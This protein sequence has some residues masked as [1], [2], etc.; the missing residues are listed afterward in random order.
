MRV[1]IAST[2]AQS[3]Q[4]RQRL[5]N[6]EETLSYELG[7]AV[8][9]LPPLYT[10]LLAGGISVLV[11]GTLTWAHFSKVDEVAVTQGELIPSVEVRP[12]RALSVGSIQ[13]IQ[14]KE[15]D[16]VKKDQVLV[17]MDSSLPQTDVNRLEKSARLIREDI[18]RLE[19]ERTGGK[20]AGTDLQDQLLTARLRE[21]DTK[22]AAAISES[23][24]QRA[25]REEAKARMSRLQENLINARDN[26]KNAR[27]REQALSSLKGT[28]AVPQL[29]YI[30]AQDELTDAKDKVVSLEKEIDA[31]LER[32]RQAD[33]AYQGA[34]S[35]A[36]GLDSQRRSE[37]LSQLN[38]RYEEQAS[39]V[40]QLEQAKKQRSRETIKSPFAGVIYNLKATRG[41]VQ[42]GEELLSIVPQDEDIL[43]EV[44]VLN[45]DIGFIKSGL[46]AKVK[47]ATF[48]YQEFGVVDGV[49]ENVSPNAIVEKDVGLVFPTRIR[50]K[51]HALQVRGKDVKLTPGM[52]A[53]AEIVT[54]K[55]SVLT[56]LIEPV[57][58]RFSEAFS[59]R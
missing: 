12:V 32:I 17:E 20:A 3:R 4:V 27:A 38:K 8:Q 13:K 37:I 54:R 16:T 10:R 50:L 34:V 35:T 55:K 11:F 58:R 59:V 43:L 46:S 48:P 40:G 45:R 15:G 53:T 47:L 44:K 2:P 1:S 22:K 26:L 7:K 5:A 56:F 23:S 21:F 41:P 31:Q 42:A 49:V 39:V 51:K 24:R 28:G 19:A 6:P 57:T 29:D 33:E 14:V 36:S 9:E 52:A 18:A 30:R 25:T